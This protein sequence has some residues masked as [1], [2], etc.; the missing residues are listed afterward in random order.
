[1]CHNFILIDVPFLN[2]C[3]H[4]WFVQLLQRLEAFLRWLCARGRIFLVP[5][6]LEMSVRRPVHLTRKCAVLRFAYGQSRK[7]KQCKLAAY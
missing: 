7:A 3:L 2:R 1:M 5:F 4:G 6:A